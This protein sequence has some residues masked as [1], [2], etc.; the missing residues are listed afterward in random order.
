MR[1]E[2]K[3]DGNSIKVW[4]N[5]DNTFITTELPDLETANEIADDFNKMSV[6]DFST[7]D[8]FTGVDLIALE[9]QRQI[10]VEGWT[11]DHDDEHSYGALATAGAMYAMPP[12]M[13][14]L[15]KTN[16]PVLWPWDEYHWKPSPDNR[17]KELAKAGALIAAE[18]D[19]LL[20][21]DRKP[22]LK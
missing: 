14:T 13:R 6:G 17:I 16:V 9:R 5:D 4:D 1:F 12:Y 19:R 11:P 3:N 7:T 2:V 10:Q 8:I 15:T 22:D 20:R 18:I 21:I